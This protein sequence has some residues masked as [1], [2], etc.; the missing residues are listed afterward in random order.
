MLSG[1]DAYVSR[2]RAKTQEAVTAHLSHLA[3]RKEGL[4]NV[5]SVFDLLASRYRDGEPSY[6]IG[7]MVLK[8][9]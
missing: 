2:E 4:S 7:S 8:L 6:H 9:S 5:G 1:I 3:P